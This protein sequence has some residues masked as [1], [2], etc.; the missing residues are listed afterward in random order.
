VLWF[1]YSL[2]I[3]ALGRRFLR[4][5]LIV[6]LVVVAVVALWYLS[7][8]ADMIRADI[9]GQTFCPTGVPDWW[10]AVLPH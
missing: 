10:P 4:L 2:P 7:G 1:C 5:G 3:L 8:T 9:D 6:G